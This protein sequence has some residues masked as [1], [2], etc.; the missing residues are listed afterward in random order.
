MLRRVFELCE[1]GLSFRTSVLE[2]RDLRF[3]TRV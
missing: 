3:Q 2:L 1:A